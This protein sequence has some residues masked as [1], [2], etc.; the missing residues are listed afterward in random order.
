MFK[1]WKLH[2]YLGNQASQIRTHF[3]EFPQGEIKDLHS[4]RD[5]SKTTQRI[6]F[7]P[8]PQNSYV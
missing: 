4:Y 1:D 8:I 5:F 7:S 6:L 2:V 3:D